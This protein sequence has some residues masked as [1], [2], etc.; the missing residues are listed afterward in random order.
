VKT[1][2]HAH[3]PA[4]T[5]RLVVDSAWFGV[6]PRCENG[7]AR[8]LDVTSV[9]QAMARGD[10]LVLNP[11]ADAGWY[12]AHFS[13]PAHGEEKVLVV[14]YH[15]ERLGAI[16]EVASDGEEGP[17]II[18]PTCNTPEPIRIESQWTR[19][20]R[21]SERVEVRVALG[22]LGLLSALMVVAAVRTRRPAC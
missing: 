2:S 4:A 9:V 18:S 19:A 12:N 8:S 6:W 3:I 21:L 15:Y 11:D 14:R 7:V 5:G 22:T 1:S 20:R 10:T 17:I 13:D 16:M